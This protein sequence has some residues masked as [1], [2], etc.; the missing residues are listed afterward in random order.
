MTKSPSVA[1]SPRQPAGDGVAADPPLKPAAT[2]R[3]STAAADPGLRPSLDSPGSL[4]P[5]GVLT[6]PPFCQRNPDNTFV[7]KE[8]VSS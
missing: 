8:P 6:I 4:I 5:N 7:S 3:A 2:G 1:S